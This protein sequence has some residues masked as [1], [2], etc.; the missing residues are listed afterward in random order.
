MFSLK[1]VADL[2]AH[3]FFLEQTIQESLR[4]LI[5]LRGFLTKLETSIHP[6]CKD[7]SSVFQEVVPS[8]FFELAYI[9]SMTLF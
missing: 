3:I 2:H 8:T 7:A 5:N 1:S 4:E 9:L 6:I